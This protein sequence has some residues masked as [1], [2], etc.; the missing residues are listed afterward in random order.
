MLFAGVVET[1]GM[2]SFCENR[3]NSDFHS[4]RVKCESMRHADG[5]FIS[6]YCWKEKR[7]S[8][9]MLRGQPV[10]K[11]QEAVRPHGQM[12]KAFHGAPY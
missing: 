1:Q 5:A 12:E 9:R 3:L 6:T 8:P 10:E 4:G 11:R 2:R 7:A